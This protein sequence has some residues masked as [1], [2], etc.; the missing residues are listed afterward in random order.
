MYQQKLDEAIEGLP[1]VSAIVDDVLVTGRTKSEMD[2]NLR[3]LLTRAREKGIRFNP[4]KCVF[5]VQEVSYFGHIL[6]SDGIKPDPEKVKA[7]EKMAA[8]ACKSELETILGMVNYLTK[9]APN[10]AEVTHPLRS[11]LKKDVEFSW[12]RP[13]QQAF[14]KVKEIITQSPVLTYF[15]P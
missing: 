6:S 10:L 9:F 14:E 8:P 1:G 4:D 2:T 7:I 12:D 15:D 5:G 11:L 13:Q 3:N